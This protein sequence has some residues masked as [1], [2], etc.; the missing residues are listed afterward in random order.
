MGSIWDLVQFTLYREILLNIRSRDV[1]MGRVGEG[2]NDVVSI[3]SYFVFLICDGY[4][5]NLAV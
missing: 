5:L 4:S 2:Q 1:M 3:E